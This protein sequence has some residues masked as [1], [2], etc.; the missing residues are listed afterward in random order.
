MSKLAI[1]E[2]VYRVRGAFGD[3][4]DGDLRIAYGL[5]R[6]E[7]S[8]RMLVFHPKDKHGC[9]SLEF[10]RIAGGT[11]NRPVYE[12]DFNGKD[13]EKEPLAGGMYINL[14][15]ANEKIYRAMVEDAGLVIPKN[16]VI[17]VADPEQSPSVRRPSARRR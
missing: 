2:L 4:G 12:S 10:A 16:L 7:D 17:S 6:D 11:R 14:S 9:G 8:D 3:M 15:S 1:K 5:T 13:P